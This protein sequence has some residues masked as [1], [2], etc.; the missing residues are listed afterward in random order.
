MSVVN[1]EPT[2]IEDVKDVSIYITSP[3]KF[4]GIR[5]LRECCEKLDASVITFCTA[6]T[7]YHKFFMSANSQKYDPYLIAVSCIYLA[8]K[9][10]DDDIKIRDIINVGYHTIHKNE[11]PLSLDPYLELRDALV[12]CELLLM[13]FLNFDLEVESPKKYLLYFIMAVKDWI[14]ERILKDVPLFHISWCILL[15]CFHMP[16]VLH[17]SAPVLAAGIL[18]LT[19]QI[20]GIVIPGASESNTN[21]WFS[22]L[23][24]HCS[25]DEVVR[26]LSDIVKFYSNE[27]Y[28]FKGVE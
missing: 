11:S 13:R 21:F 3:S 4:K 27:D 23:H 8:S 19:L 14:G 1:L 9:V 12:E 15:D 10:E 28:F 16:F 20:Y 17:Y 6:S 18:L 2:K 5:F 24:P 25:K 7:Y 22:H 26:A